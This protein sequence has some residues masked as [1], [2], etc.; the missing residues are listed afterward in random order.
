ML[1]FREPAVCSGFKICGKLLKTP[2][3]KTFPIPFNKMPYSPKSFFRA[4]ILMALCLIASQVHASVDAFIWFDSESPV[5]AIKGTSQDTVFPASKGWFEIK[6]FSFGVE[7]PTTIGSATTGGG[8]GKIKFNE[9]TIKKT[10]DVN[11]PAFFKNCASGVHYK[12]VTL[13]LRKAGGSSATAG[14]AYL[15]YRFDTVFTTKVAWSGPGDEGPEESITFVYGSINITYRPQNTDGLLD[16]L[17][18]TESWDQIRNI[19]LLNPIDPD[20]VP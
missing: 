5:T 12:T 15:V 9:F 18:I 2:F 3:M 1:R 14:G 4:A 19:G 13:A 6:D 20:L 10:S 11:S 8:T 7:N 17:G 16:R